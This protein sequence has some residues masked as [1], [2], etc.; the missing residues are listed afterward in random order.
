[1]E[2][3]SAACDPPGAYE[4]ASAC[5]GW[6]LKKPKH[7]KARALKLQQQQQQQ[8]GL[9]DLERT[10]HPRRSVHALSLF[11]SSPHI[12]RAVTEP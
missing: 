12:A 9:D 10:L 11:I 3:A 6:S 5:G 7:R 2:P 4:A 8:R 1:M